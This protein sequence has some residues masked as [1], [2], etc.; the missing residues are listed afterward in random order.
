MDD[1]VCKAAIEDNKV[2]IKD[3]S[4][5]IDMIRLEVERRGFSMEHGARTG[6]TLVNGSAN[7][8]REESSLGPEVE[9]GGT[10]EQVPHSSAMGAAVEGS[11]SA[12]HAIT[13]ENA[14]AEREEEGVYL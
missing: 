7:I 12:A 13:E 11:S 8:E 5:R 2:V 1:P 14:D 4:D 6:G 9:M 10:G 3:Q